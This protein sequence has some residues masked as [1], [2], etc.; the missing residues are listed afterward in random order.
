MAGVASY[1]CFFEVDKA[2]GGHTYAWYFKAAEARGRA[3][4]ETPVLLWLQGG[5]GGASTFGALN[6]VGPVRIALREDGTLG[7]VRREHTWGGAYDMLFLDNPVGTGFS[8]TRGGGY[9]TKREDYAA[10]LYSATSQFYQMFP[11]KRGAPLFLTGESYAGKYIPVLADKI[12][13]ENDARAGEPPIPLAGIAVGDGWSDPEVMVQGYPELF[14]QM[15]LIDRDQ[16]DL[17]EKESAAAVAMIREGK[18]REAFLVWDKLLNGDLSGQPSYFLNVTG[19]Q[20]YFN[21][22]Q[23]QYPDFDLWEA[24]LDQADTRALLNVNQD[25]AFNGSSP[26]VEEKLVEDVMRSVKDLMPGLLARYPCLFYSGQLDLIVGGPLTDAFLNSIVWP[27]RDAFR[28]SKREVW[29]G[30][31]D[32]VQGYKRSGGNLTQVIIRN[33]GHLA[34]TDQPQWSLDMIQ[35]FVEGRL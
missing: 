27:G 10:T 16:A 23:P 34:P 18:M 15:S 17:L 21:V 4:A 26:V 19:L 13:R 22:L 24:W 2:A 29:R 5:P 3:D 1:S 20:D 32:Q 33:A 7:P 14:Y 25:V 35:H 9:A 8:F 6:E 28:S 12:M 31:D 11:A 30:V